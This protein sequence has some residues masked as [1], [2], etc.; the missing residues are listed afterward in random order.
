[1]GY[2][3][4]RFLQNEVRMLKFCAAEKCAKD[5]KIIKIRGWARL[6][7]PFEQFYCRFL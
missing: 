3:A 2:F 6:L 4:T 5:E 1:M 7:G